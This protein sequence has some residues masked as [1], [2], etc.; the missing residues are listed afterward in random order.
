MGL[1]LAPSL[2]LLGAI[3]VYPIFFSVAR[4]L[5]DSTGSEF[6]GVENYRVMFTSAGRSPRSGTT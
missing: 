5:F 6:V 4:S 3:V 2:V 1:F